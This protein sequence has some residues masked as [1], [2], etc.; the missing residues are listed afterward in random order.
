MPRGNN[1]R[2][3][4]EETREALREIAGWRSDPA[5]PVACPACAAPG[6]VIVDRSARPYAE[7]YALSCPACGL[8]ATV[9]V[10]MAPPS[11]E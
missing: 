9:H 7:W 10:P 1:R 4:A 5:R 2:L 6:L 8:D 3:T 11:Y